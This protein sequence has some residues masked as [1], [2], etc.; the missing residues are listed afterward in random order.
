MVEWGTFADWKNP[1]TGETA[2][3]CPQC[4]CLSEPGQVSSLAGSTT[5][6]IFREPTGPKGQSSSIDDVTLMAY[7][8]YSNEC[9]P[10]FVSNNGSTCEDYEKK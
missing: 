10:N 1:Y 7:H 4:G 9:D 6:S 2:W 8:V 3:S 5:Y